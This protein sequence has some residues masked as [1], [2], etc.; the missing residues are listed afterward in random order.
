MPRSVKETRLPSFS[1][2]GLIRLKLLYGNEPGEFIEELIRGELDAALARPRYERSRK[3]GH[4]GKPGMTGHR[5]GSRPRSLIG[6]FGPIEIAVPRARLDTPTARPPSGR[7][8]RCGPTS[9]AR[10]PP[11][12]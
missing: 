6:S 10:W 1:T 8:R 3:V 9:A 11:T 12:H 2:I 5:H 4:E 7:A